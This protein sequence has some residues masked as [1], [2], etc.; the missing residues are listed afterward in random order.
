MARIVDAVEEL[1]LERWSTL[2][3]RPVTVAT[4]G[5]L[6]TYAN[7]HFVAD[8]PVTFGFTSGGAPLVAGTTYYVRDVTADTFRVAATVGGVA[9]DVTSD[10]VGRVWSGPRPSYID[11]ALIMQAAALYDRRKTSNGVVAGSDTLGPFRVGRF[12]PD[13]ERM[14][15]DGSWGVR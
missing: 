4:I 6:V 15:D 1:W 2:I 8:T 13:V 14:I 3:A 9:I 11:Q 5:G 10:G 7:H 12:D